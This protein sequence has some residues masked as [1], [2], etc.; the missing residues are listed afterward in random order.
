M[1][2]VVGSG[3]QMC[4]REVRTV[5]LQANLERFAR[6]R[7]LPYLVVLPRF[8]SYRDRLSFVL[9]GSVATGLCNEA[10]DIDI[11]IVCDE[12]I[13]N[14]IS[15]N[16]VWSKRRPTE[17][18]LDGVQLH[19]Y[20][21]TFEEILK[22]VEELDDIR[23]YVYGIFIPLRDPDSQYTERMGALFSNNSEIRKLRLEAKLDM[24]IRR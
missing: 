4:R 18:H 20:A 3:A 13:Y 10:S 5:E 2:E 14:A 23:L 6:D 19:Y 9:I 7:C 24:L 11:A 17:V 21:T 8:R 12:G 22:G 16:T 15:Q 1:Q